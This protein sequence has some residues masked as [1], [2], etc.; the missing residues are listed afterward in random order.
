MKLLNLKVKT[1]NRIQKFAK[2][3]RQ[4]MKMNSF[5]SIQETKPDGSN[6]KGKSFFPTLNLLMWMMGGS[7]II[8]L[9]LVVALVYFGR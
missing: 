2:Y 1:Q 9:I 6:A 4:I 7:V 3:R 8:L 5:Q